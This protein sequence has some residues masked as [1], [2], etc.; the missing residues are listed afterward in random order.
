MTGAPDRGP[1]G[2]PSEGEWLRSALSAAHIVALEWD[3]RRRV[4]RLDGDA[5]SL[6]GV[7]AG[8]LD[9][10]LLT[11]RIHPV[12]LQRI[13][14]KW[15]N[16]RNLGGEL[17]IEFRIQVGG[18]ERWIFGHGAWA[19]ERIRGILQD[20]TARK[21]SDF[22][23]ILAEQRY[24]R[25]VE[26]AAEIICIL[27]AQ[28][29]VQFANP[30]VAAVTGYQIDDIASR[31][32]FD[33]V[34]EEDRSAAEL[35]FERRR[36]GVQERYEMRIRRKDG[37]PMWLD[38]SS[39]PMLDDEGRF[40]GSL[41]LGTVINERKEAEAT[42]ARQR[43]ALERSNADLQ[44]FA[45]VTSH[46]LQEPL[47]AIHTYT[48]LLAGR[49]KNIFDEEGVHFLSYIAGS[50]SRMDRL[51]RDLLTY[52]RVVNQDPP[53]FE[54]VPLGPVV[55]WAMMNLQHAMTEADAL[56]EFDNLPEVYGDRTELIQLFQNLLSN[57]IKYRGQERPVIQIHGEEMPD[58][59]YT[60]SVSDNGIG[61]A[62]EYHDRVF[63]LF[64][65]LHGHEYPGT[66]LGLAICKR[67]VEKHGG[68]I[69]VE[70]SAGKGAKFVFTLP[71]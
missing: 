61:I 17:R 48:Q 34:F 28:G 22:E 10:G 49:Y 13:Y 58:G 35:K 36:A 19:G 32:V 1:S 23:A 29:R 15:D 70:S 14:E 46:D 8:E 27:D 43:E 39:T 41:L 57:A 9:P 21:Q 69:W 6:L 33:V 63:G 64:K 37:V 59:M 20:V 18:T 4:F 16:F 44:Q 66:G 7:P 62:P 65:R 5:E 71:G 24:R 67:I 68:R 60:I 2:S 12:D 38:I 40:S 47:R 31:S 25:I 42:L 11:H 52:S 3:R 51:I 30:A 26:T 54:Q 50:A 45:Y 55:Q 56:I 53:P